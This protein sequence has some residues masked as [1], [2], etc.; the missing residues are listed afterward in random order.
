MDEQ[1]QLEL[2]KRRYGEA[3]RASQDWRQEAKELY[4][5]VAGHQWSEEDRQRM[6]D[7]R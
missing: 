5:L 3:E 7:Q 4:D 6:M 1:E 2:L